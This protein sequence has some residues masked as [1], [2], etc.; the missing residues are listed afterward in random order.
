MSGRPLLSLTPKQ[1]T[2]RELRLSERER[3]V[4][5]QLYIRGRETCYSY[6]GR[7]RL[8]KGRDAGDDV[9]G[10]TR[11]LVVLL[12]LRQICDHP[13]LIASS[14]EGSQLK[15]IGGVPSKRTTVWLRPDVDGEPLRR[16][17]FGNME[18][19]VSMVLECCQAHMDGSKALGVSSTTAL[20]ARVVWSVL[21]SACGGITI[22]QVKSLIRPALSA[23]LAEDPEALSDDQF[24]S[25]EVD[26]DALADSLTES[27]VF[28]FHDNKKEKHE[29]GK[30]SQNRE[31]WDPLY[32]S[33]KVTHDT[34]QISKKE[35][36]LLPSITGITV[37][38]DTKI[39]VCAV[40][41]LICV[42]EKQS[43]QDGGRDEWG[44]TQIG[45]N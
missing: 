23:E 43:K 34:F 22:D 21:E 32:A 33:T 3:L 24:W 18:E 45:A 5:D 30:L 25:A 15:G 9:W 11:V 14:A 38:F 39:C 12:R 13:C 2:L 10:F 16:L 35:H 28:E 37:H 42:S 26:M 40:L 27:D 19:L 20:T 41:L 8:P 7:G 1:I 29:D 17:P 31:L 36:V 6:A 44:R 4:Y